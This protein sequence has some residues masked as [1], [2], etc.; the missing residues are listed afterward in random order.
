MRSEGRRSRARISSPL[1]PAAW[2]I[3][4]NQALRSRA[5]PTGPKPWARAQRR[6]SC[7]SCES[8]AAVTMSGPPNTNGPVVG[9]RLSRAPGLG[10]GPRRPAGRSSRA[11][12][13]KCRPRPAR[14]GVR[15][16]QSGSA[17]H[18]EPSGAVSRPATPL[19]RPHGARQATR[20]GWQVAFHGFAKRVS[21]GR[22]AVG[23]G[24]VDPGQ[25][26]TTSLKPHSSSWER[27]FQETGHAR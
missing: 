22:K 26:S 7:E 24:S 3:V 8:A 17:P 19:V 10:D 12:S 5:E 25:I 9:N 18:S 15:R 16:A 6:A 27:G 13:E 2:A 23:A 20:V 11:P 1:Q 14:S 21:F 4:W